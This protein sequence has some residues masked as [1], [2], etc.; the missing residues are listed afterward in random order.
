M[1]KTFNFMKDTAPAR[2]HPFRSKQQERIAKHHNVTRVLEFRYTFDLPK[3]I[4]EAAKES[5]YNAVLLGYTT[6][7]SS[8]WG[9][10]KKRKR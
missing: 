6:G 5:G 3:Y 8:T 9:F 4:R 10:S 2:R 1:A 7:K